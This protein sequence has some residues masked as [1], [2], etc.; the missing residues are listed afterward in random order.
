MSTTK[1]CKLLT[2]ILD[3]KGVEVKSHREY[4][5][6]GIILQVELVLDG[7]P[8]SLLIQAERSESPVVFALDVVKKVADYTKTIV[9]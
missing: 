7:D 5:G 3:L 8:P 6:I 9:T 1:E 2:Q 4:E